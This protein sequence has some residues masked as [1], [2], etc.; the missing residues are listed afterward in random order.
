MIRSCDK[1]LTVKGSIT[2]D[3]NPSSPA[4]IEILMKNKEL[5]REILM[6][7]VKMKNL[8]APSKIHMV[9]IYSFLAPKPL[10]MPRCV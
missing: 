9:C 6:K 3:K 1:S 5:P 10:E 2:V 8:S 4:A 7:Q